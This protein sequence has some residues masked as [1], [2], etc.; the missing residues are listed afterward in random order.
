MLATSARVAK[1]HRILAGDWESAIGRLQEL[2]LAN[3]GED[4]FQEIFKLLVAKLYAEKFPGRGPAFGAK[5]SCEAT[6]NAVNDLLARAGAR[7]PGIIDGDSRSRLADDHLAV[8]VEAIAAHSLCDTT[9]EVLDSFFEFLVSRVAKGSKGQYFTPRQVIECCVRIINPTP[10]ETVLDPACGS[11]GFLVHVLNHNAPRLT[12]STRDYCATKLWGCDFD[13]RAIQVAKALMLLAADDNSNLYQINSLLQPRTGSLLDVDQD[14]AHLTIEDLLRSKVRGFRGFDVIV[15]NP[16]F[17]G[18]IRESSLLGAYQV[19]KRNRRMERDALFLERCVQLLKPGGRLGIVLPHNKFGS[20]SWAY[21]RQWLIRHVRVAVVL[22]L[23][24]TAFLPHT[25]QKTSVLFGVKRTRP[26][27]NP[28]G[29]PVLF[30]LSES[31]GKDSKGRM[32][33][34]AGVAPDDPAWVR[35]DHDFEG[36]VAEAGAFARTHDLG[37][38]I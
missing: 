28:S 19:A 4:E 11:G 37:W 7:W 16:P 33:E 21:L 35:A 26:V 14:A 25:H 2:V 9:F 15:T 13:K 10:S 8:C 20:A 27:R 6:A 1:R 38:S 24:R 12:G 34:R 22:G 5:S 30:L 31:S 18:E 3:S 23:D 17:A 29:E 32:R 36:I